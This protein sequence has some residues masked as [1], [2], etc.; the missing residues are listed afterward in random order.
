M[1]TEASEE[2]GKSSNDSP[3]QASEG[4]V[5]EALMRELVKLR[6]KRKIGQEPIAQAIGITQG[7]VSQMESLK[8]GAS[9]EAVLL[10]A[11]AIGADIVVVPTD[12]K[13]KSAT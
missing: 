9:L 11:R 1:A 12:S 7:R 2:K 13:K 3:H 6:K 10:Y 4:L 5:C 8:S